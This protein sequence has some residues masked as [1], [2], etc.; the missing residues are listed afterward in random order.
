MSKIRSHM[1]HIPCVCFG[2]KTRLVYGGGAL[3]P[4]E[5][6]TLRAIGHGFHNLESL[7]EILGL[8]K[9]PVLDLIYDAWLKGYITVDTTQGRVQLAGEAAAAFASGQ[10]D[11]LGTMENIVE[12]VPLMREL[13]SGAILPH[14]GSLRPRVQE[15]SL[16]PTIETSLDLLSI[17]SGEIHAAVQSWARLES[18]RRQ[19][20]I[21]ILEAW[22]DYHDFIVGTNGVIGAGG[23]PAERSVLTVFAD[24]QY[25]SGSKRLSF[26]LVEASE[27]APAARRRVA[28]ALSDLADRMPEQT[29]FRRIFREFENSA[30]FEEVVRSIGAVTGLQK[31]CAN[32]E[33]VDRGLIERRHEEL[34]N[35]LE[36]A[37]EEV[38]E[39]LAA[40]AAIELVIGYSGHETKIQRLVDR[41]QRQLILGNP[42]IDFAAL[43]DPVPDCSFSWFDLLE[44]ALRRNVQIF[45]LWGISA[46]ATLDDK[47]ASALSDLQARYP[48][49]LWFSRKSSIIHA[50][51]VICD[52]S[53]ALITSFN[54]L[55]PSRNRE[56]LELGLLIRERRE[57]VVPEAILD[58]LEWSRRIFPDHLISRRILLLPED[59]GARD[60]EIPDLPNAP[61]L[62][63]AKSADA[64]ISL[65]PAA[66]RHWATAWRS[67][68]GRLFEI[69]QQVESNA[70]LL[71]DRAHRDS[72]L[73][74]ARGSQHRFAVLSDRVSVDV[75]T[76]HFASSV[77]D[78]LA[79]GVPCVFLY[80]REGA[81]D[82]QEGPAERL[83][84]LARRSP[85]S[86]TLIEAPSHAKV[87][88]SDDQ[89]TVGS[90][91]FLSFGGE[92][93][94]GQQERAELSLLIHDSR[95]VDEVLTA[96][97]RQWAG[98]FAPLIG[99][100]RSS[101]L[102]QA[103][104]PPALQPL[105]RSMESPAK[106][107]LVLLRWFERS[108]DPWV[109]LRGIE[110]AAVPTELLA[111]ATAAALSRCPNIDDVEAQAWRRRLA[112]WRW[113]KQDFAGVAMLLPDE[114]DSS[115]SRS[116]AEF[117]ASVFVGSASDIDEQTAL[118]ASQSPERETIALSLLV[119]ILVH[120]R[121]DLL[122]A[123][124]ELEQ[125]SDDVALRWISACVRYA[126]ATRQPLPL[127]LLQGSVG[128]EQRRA[129]IARAKAELEHALADA[130]TIN[131]RFSIGGRIWAHL[132]QEGQPLGE[133]RL[134]H[135]RDDPEHLAKF[136][137]GNLEILAGAWIDEAS[138]QI[139]NSRGL[140][141]EGR[142]RKTCVHRLVVM[143]KAARSWLEQSRS[144]ESG[145]VDAKIIDSC[146]QL[147]RDLDG[148]RCSDFHEE[149]PVLRPVLSLT[150]AMLS[151]LLGA[152]VP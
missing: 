74:A 151:S 63:L 125:R 56:S 22:P 12:T 26:D 94:S 36:E 46:R 73:E 68:A 50:K 91:N 143:V 134:A 83:S 14:A 112:G 117:V 65:E 85:E 45:V 6:T 118:A 70:R 150:R 132:K 10:L 4:V 76:D 105:F 89:V 121:L 141:I 113:E 18:N 54:F 147:R 135:D 2:V 84:Q 34:Q 93:T 110:Q 139:E 3:T 104:I 152:T 28:V 124:R 137:D 120:G 138:T 103:D 67:V 51:F 129:D 101:V 53:E 77:E 62:P 32:L 80:R 17:S 98:K 142:K 55:K 61:E 11:Q 33:T 47:V 149:N 39:S 106:R 72:L 115:P 19:R 131:F 60:P 145:D 64:G 52:A 88:I 116:L 25:D 15:S 86:C 133:C 148:L 37:H 5:Y 40:D 21:R 123:A 27:L 92:Y 7:E 97:D 8:G 13:A 146:H 111:Q 16:V 108:E 38:R 79:A 42:W 130:E 90:F 43:L 87:L 119:A 48:D 126:T 58:L 41:A 69:K 29:F 128:N 99:L 127:A 20:D 144:S 9:R 107:G 95:M 24:I 102:P 35:Q 78:R 100:T 82:Q 71:I 59:F 81:S 66:I 31:K 1:I 96:L 122:S 23:G 136:V 109:D 44:N 57:R 140:L 75:V 114:G 30:D 49:R